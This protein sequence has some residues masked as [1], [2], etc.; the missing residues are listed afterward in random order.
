MLGHKTECTG[1][2]RISGIAGFRSQNLLSVSLRHP[3][4]LLGDM[5]ALSDSV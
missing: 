3:S 1:R 5:L 4:A 2:G